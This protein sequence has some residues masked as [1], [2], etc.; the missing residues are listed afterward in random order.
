MTSIFNCFAKLFHIKLRKPQQANG[1]VA[2]TEEKVIAQPV[3][4]AVDI[5]GVV[6]PSDVY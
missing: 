3:L 4:S 5:G 6:E 2:S 1:V